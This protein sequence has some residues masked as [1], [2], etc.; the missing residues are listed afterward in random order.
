MASSAADLRRY[1]LTNQEHVQYGARARRSLRAGRCPASQ[2]ASDC[3]P[4]PVCFRDTGAG[5]NPA[6]S[7]SRG[8]VERGADP[9]P[10]VP[11]AC[12]PTV[13]VRLLSSSRTMNCKGF[14]HL[15][16]PQLGESELEGR[17]HGSRTL[18]SPS[19][20]SRRSVTGSCSSASIRRMSSVKF[21]CGSIPRCL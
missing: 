15:W 2:E 17:R 8:R 16:H 5:S 1:Q 9:L 19:N 20:G 11:S 21:R 3:T 18:G 10:L 12:K 14:P 4:D 13:A 6:P 7:E